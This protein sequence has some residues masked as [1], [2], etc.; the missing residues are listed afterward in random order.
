MCHD[1]ALDWAISSYF[2]YK[3]E[4]KKPTAKEE[5]VEEKLP[6]LIYPFPE[7]LNIDK[8]KVVK[9]RFQDNSSTFR[10]VKDWQEGETLQT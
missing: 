7:I 5:K 4:K 3:K 8:S 9:T 6:E 2:L 10:I 1:K